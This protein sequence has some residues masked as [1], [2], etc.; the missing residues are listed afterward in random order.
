MEV[1]EKLLEYLFFLSGIS[2]III[3]L[4]I[5]LFIAVT[6]I[7]F[8]QE[9]GLSE[10][11]NTDWNPTIKPPKW[12]ALSLFAG[13]FYIAA[14]AMSISIPT[15]LLLAI[16]M[17]E[18]ASSGVR[19]N[20]K[21]LIESIAGIPTVVLGLFGIIFL[22]PHLS[23]LFGIPLALNALNAGILVGFLAIPTIASISE[24]VLG[25]IPR[26]FRHASEGLGA[27]KWQTIVRVVL[28]A[29]MGGIFASIMLALGRVIGET[30]VVLMVAGMVRAF[31][32]SILDPVSPITATIASELPETVVGDLHYQGLFALGL[33]LFIVTF[34]INLL[35]DI[36]LER[37]KR[38]FGR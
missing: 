6:G 27:T 37:Y 11:L 13:T 23:S 24:D 17:S 16:Y 18:V 10:F 15:G 14:I 31:P 29:G 12:G 3:L 36:I 2:A 38:R 22:A 8:F 20:L 25:S 9:V 26:D 32:R 30:M 7:Q 34:M 28:P 35:A 21:P 19:E 1:K 5:I 33:T 4:A